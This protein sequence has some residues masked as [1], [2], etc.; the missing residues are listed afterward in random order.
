MPMLYRVEWTVSHPDLFTGGSI[1]PVSA[2]CKVSP[3]NIANTKEE[4]KFLLA[5]SFL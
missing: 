1:V 4:K 5:S 2:S 3:M